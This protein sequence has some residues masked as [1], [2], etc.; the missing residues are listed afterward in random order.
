MKTST[1]DRYA[2][3]TVLDCRKVCQQSFGEAVKFGLIASN[4]FDLVK[5]PG[6]PRGI[7]TVDLVM[8]R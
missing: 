3:F 2:P 8:I 7:R 6:V 4:P 1:F 5:A